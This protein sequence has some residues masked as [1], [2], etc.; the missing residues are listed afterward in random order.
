MAFLVSCRPAEN[1]PGGGGG[2]GGVSGGAQ[3]AAPGAGQF[4]QAGTPAGVGG[5]NGG[6]GGDS[7][8]SGGSGM[9]GGAS[10]APIGG[11]AGTRQPTFVKQRL[12]AEFYSEGIN[13]GDID[14]DGDE[15]IVAGPYWYPGPQFTEQRA[16]REPRG[17]PFDAS[18]DSDCYSIFLYDFS[19][20]GWLDI[21]SVRLPGGA[22]GV[23][24]ENP[25]GADD[26]WTEH[27]AYGTID[28]ESAAL[29]DID[30][31]GK[32]ELVTNSNGYGGWAHPD[33]S[34]PTEPWSFRSVTEQGSWAI[35]THGIGAGDINGDDRADLLLPEG[36]WEQPPSGSQSWAPHPA[37][38]WGQELASES[39]G[40]AQ[41]FADDV[42]GDGDND[43]VTSLQAHGW[44]LAWFEQTADGFVKH[45]VMNTREEE[46]QY[47]AAFAQLHA[48]ALADLDGDGLKDIVTGK[49]KGAHGNGLGTELDA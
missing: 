1:S 13:Y 6:S 21:F 23:W 48:V 24:Y 20:D 8:A 15:D 44:G 2:T 12:D 25:Q 19:Q 37:E 5:M 3:G 30:A 9:S 14:G 42:D 45:L 47:G 35:Y 10:G 41:M 36:W 39:Y 29:L 4:G 18:G 22:E 26:Y 17:T 16:F 40:G 49:R 32:P 27:A 46:A 7:A 11:G 31:D 43:V 33:W 34:Q 28:N 38:F